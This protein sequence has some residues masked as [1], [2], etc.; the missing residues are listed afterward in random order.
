M[1]QH[2]N[3]EVTS[4]AKLGV[5]PDYLMNMLH[6]KQ[7]N[8]EYFSAIFVTSQSSIMYVY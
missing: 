5:L 3:Y 8:V 7:A 6:L 2:T 4:N 1:N